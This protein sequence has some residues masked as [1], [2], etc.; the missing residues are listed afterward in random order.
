MGQKVL[1]HTKGQ[2]VTMG[3]KSQWRERRWSR[4]LQ[5]AEILAIQGPKIPLL[6]PNVTRHKFI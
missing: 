5:E 1:L 4:G 3:A 6:T 2:N